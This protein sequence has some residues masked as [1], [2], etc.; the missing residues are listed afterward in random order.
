MSPGERF[1]NDADNEPFW[2]FFE[3]RGS[4]YLSLFEL[5]WTPVSHFELRW[6]PWLIFLMKKSWTLGSLSPVEPF[7]TLVIFWPLGPFE[8]QT[9]KLH[10]TNFCYEKRWWALF[11]YIKSKTSHAHFWNEKMFIALAFIIWAPVSPFEHQR[12]LLSTDEPP[13]NA[14]DLQTLRGSFLKPWLFLSRWALLSSFDPFNL[15]E[16]LWALHC[17]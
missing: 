13:S 16:L 3:A 10:V 11:S 4:D 1:T 9:I 7:W 6:A 5:F 12:G 17:T 8:L 2:A 15:S 14:F